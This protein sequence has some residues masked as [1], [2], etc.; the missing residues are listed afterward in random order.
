[1]KR[2]RKK[3][4]KEEK[5]QKEKE[6]KKNKTLTLF[7]TTQKI[8][9]NKFRLIVSGGPCG[10]LGLDHGRQL[11]QCAA[12]SLLVPLRPRQRLDLPTQPKRLLGLAHLALNCQTRRH[13]AALHRPEKVEEE[14]DDEN[15]ENEEEEDL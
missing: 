13:S 14:D 9:M 6:T 5:A 2:R 1:M 12:P 4:K 15:E 11:E 10:V 8:K 3:K 7:M